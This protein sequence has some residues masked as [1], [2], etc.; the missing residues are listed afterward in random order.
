MAALELRPRRGRHMR[1]GPARREAGCAAPLQPGHGRQRPVPRDACK[2]GRWG[3]G[4]A[5]QALEQRASAE[6]EARIAGLLQ[7]E[8]ELRAAVERL[9][10]Q[11]ASEADLA[12]QRVQQLERLRAAESVAA[13]RACAQV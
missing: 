5:A 11:V 6:Q 10:A 1:P 7:R 13:Q 8:K 2:Q 3:A 9:E 12:A 4:Q